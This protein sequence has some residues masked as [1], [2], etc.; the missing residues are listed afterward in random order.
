MSHPHQPVTSSGLLNSDAAITAVGGYLHAITLISDAT[1]TASIVIY[2]SPVANT[3]AL[4]L[5]KLSIPATTTAPQTITFN[6]PVSA[7][8]GIYAD[9]SGT[10]ANYIVYYSQGI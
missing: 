9:V 5:A 6:N 10:G 2:D 1:N 3:G 8:K 7:N 4:I